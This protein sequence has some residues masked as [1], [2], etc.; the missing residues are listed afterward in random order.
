MISAKGPEA[1]RRKRLWATLIDFGLI[2]A[3]AG[4]VTLASGLFETADAYLGK[5]L[6]LR[7][8]GVLIVSY[9][10]LNLWPLARSGQ[11]WGKRWLGLRIVATQTQ[12][13]SAVLPVWRLLVRAFTLL[14]FSALPLFNYSLLLLHV[15][16][17]IL[18][19]TRSKRCLHDYLA[20]TRVVA[21]DNQATLLTSNLDST[22]REKL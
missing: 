2:G 10:A 18:I 6:P 22:Q 8:I 3:V 17:P 16:D 19:F 9:L 5:Q 14:L 20:S 13:D 7:V 12:S 11:T 1:S 21:G 4:L 15:I